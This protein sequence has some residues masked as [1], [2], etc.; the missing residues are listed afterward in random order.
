MSIL[1]RGSEFVLLDG[2]AVQLDYSASA[3][4]VERHYR[5]GPSRRPYDDPSFLHREAAFEGVGLRPYA[6]AHLRASRQP[7]GAVVVSWIR[8]SRVDGDNWIG[9]DIPLGEE[10]ELYRVRVTSE[11]G[12]IR[13]TDV[14]NASFTYT[15]DAWEQ[16]GRPASIGFEIAQISSRV[17]PGPFNRIQLHV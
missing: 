16:D 3:R 7:S 15:T 2:A 11:R 13:E 8:R 17:G 6:P 5:V 12:R 14:P 9:E 10:R 4:G 1:P